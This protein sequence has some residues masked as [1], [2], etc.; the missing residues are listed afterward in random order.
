[1]KKTNK[2]VILSI[3]LKGATS[4]SGS[5][6]RSNTKKDR[7]LPAKSAMTNVEDHSR[8]NKSSVKRKN[9]VDS[10]ISYKRTVINSNS[11][12]ICK[13]CNIFL[14]SF[15]HDK[16]GMKSLKFVKKPHVNKVWRVKQVKQ[17]WQHTVKL[18][19]TVSHQWK[20][21]RRTFT[22]G[23]QYPLTRSTISKVVPAIQPDNVSSSAIVIT[24][25]LSNT[26]QKPLTS[27]EKLNTFVAKYE[28]FITLNDYP[29]CLLR[30][31][32]RTATYLLKSDSYPA[33]TNSGPVDSIRKDA[34]QSGRIVTLTT[35]DIQKKKNNV[36]ARTTLLLS[37]PD[38]HQTRHLF[39][40]QRTAAMKMTTLYVL[41]LLALHFPL[42]IKFK[43]INQIDDDDIEEMDIKWNMAL[44]SM[45]ADKFWKITGKKIS[46][47]GSDVAGFDKSKVKC[48]NCHKMCHFA[49]ECKAPRSQERGRKESYR[50]G[51]GF[52][53]DPVP[54]A[55]YVPPTNKDLKILFQPMFDEYFKLPGIKRPVPPAS[56]VQVPIVSAGTPSSITIDQ[57]APSTSYSPLSSIVQ[58]PITHQSVA[59]RPTIEDNPFAQTDNDPFVNVFA[60]EPSSDESSSWDVSSSLQPPISHQG[61]A[62]GPAIEDNPFAQVNNDPF[63]NVF[64]PKPSSDESSSEDFSSA[65]STQVVH[66]HNHLRKWSKDHPL[67]NVIGNPSRLVSIEK[68]LATDAL[69]CFYNSILSKVEPKNVKTAMDEACCE[70]ISTI[71]IA[72]AASKNM[73]IYQMDI[74]KVKLDEYSDV[75]KNKARLVVKGY[76]QEEGIDFEESFTPDAR[77]E[78]IRI[79]I[80][81]SK[82][83]IIY[84]MDV[85]TAFLNGELKEE[86]YISQLEGFIDL[87]HLTHV[88]HLKKALYGLKKA[89][90]A[91]LSLPKSTS[92]QLNGSF[93]I[94]EEPLAGDS[95]SMAISTTE[96]EYIAMSECYAQ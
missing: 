91:W 48:F 79:F 29:Q 64:A 10:S 37:L 28:T 53:P 81:N 35:D 51:S 67:D 14:M 12:S 24:E 82:N 83:M 76:I 50:Q 92:R 63:V 86:V 34:E 1:M 60:P 18:F 88:Y 33:P 30:V 11:D 41:P 26:S 72:N 80:A 15:N 54:T 94:F 19:A 75:L 17:V 87:D 8:D 59:A 74:Y 93:G 56:A 58:H 71:F 57:D 70:G 49:R 73:I 85:K 52:L 47:Q 22:L 21:T 25:R 68:Q 2:P 61:V 16:C 6:L 13:P 66:P 5:K 84:Q 89:P 95:E 69:W 77:I 78:A 32:L 20:P 9:R 45:R 3:G 40:P 7:S 65:E 96:A 42:A 27:V 43:D 38:E 36:K 39:L 46:K 4:T 55:P 23:E 62:A 90:R 31:T 44:L